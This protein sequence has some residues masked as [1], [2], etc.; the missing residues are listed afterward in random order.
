MA[1]YLDLH[2]VKPALTSAV[3]GA[4]T[5]KTEK[6]LADIQK[7]LQATI[8]AKRF[9][10]GEEL[11]GTF[12]VIGSSK[13]VGLELAKLAQA[14]GL[15]TYGTCRKASPDL[16]ASGVTI[17]EGIELSDDDCGEKLKAALAG[18]E[19]NT[20]VFNAALGDANAGGENAMI[21]VG[22]GTQ[23]LDSLTM[24]NMRK[25]MEVNAFGLL[26]VCQAIVPQIKKNGGRLC[27]VG[28]VAASFIWTFDS[29]FS[30][31][32][33]A[34]FLAYR[35]S[36]VAAMMITQTLAG[37]LAKDGIAVS[38]IHPGVG[39]TDL[40]TKGM[41]PNGEPIIPPGMEGMM[42]WPSDLAKGVMLAVKNTTMTNTGL[43]LDGQYG[44]ACITQPW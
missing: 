39:A 20:L 17:I 33:F 30:S 23:G 37:P 28:T 29:P 38:V 16:T 43:F 35:A 11:T 27:T 26:K 36:K 31:G 15:K 13:G 14:A 19:I 7:S 9:G 2:G 1:D 6:P 8:D 12:V 3:K 22:T 24:E 21:S 10:A 5:D 42:K 25:M 4:I 44:E 32:G 18:V 34:P 40:T 41:G